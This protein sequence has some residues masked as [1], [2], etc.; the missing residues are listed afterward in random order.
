MKHASLNVAA[1]A[2]IASLA[3]VGCKKNEP[4][5]PP[6]A[7]APTAPAPAP[8]APAPETPAAPVPEKRSALPAD[9]LVVADRR[10]EIFA[11]I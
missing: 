2:V 4:A 9:T 3:L 8:A 1:L 10:V 5:N 6:P 11:T 7:P